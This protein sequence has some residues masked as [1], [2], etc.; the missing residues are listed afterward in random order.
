MMILVVGTLGRKREDQSE[1]CYTSASC[2]WASE[3]HS[4]NFRQ[5]LQNNE[6]IKSLG[7]KKNLAWISLVKGR[8]R[9]LRAVL[10]HHVGS[11]D[12]LL[13]GWHAVVAPFFGEI[14]I[15]FFLNENGGKRRNKGTVEKFIHNR[16]TIDWRHDESIRDV[17][18]FFPFPCTAIIRTASEDRL[19]IPFRLTRKQ[20]QCLDD[21][22]PFADRTSK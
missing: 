6:I 2:K 5:A 9:N 22:F 4:A 14:K 10:L 12:W 3:H 11:F 19:G 1:D 21:S 7:L 16:S 18:Y 13:I 15:K 20:R 17:S 8:R